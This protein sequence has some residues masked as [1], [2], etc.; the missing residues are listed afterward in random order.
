MFD[1]LTPKI[2][3]SC[4]GPDDVPQEVFNLCDIGLLVH[5]ATIK[6]E[7]GYEYTVVTNDLKKDVKQVICELNTILLDRVQ[8]ANE[9]RDPLMREYN[10]EDPVFAV[11]QGKLIPFSEVRR[12]T[13]KDVAFLEAYNNKKIF[14]KL[15]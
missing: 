6:T 3:S 8:K 2:D 12:F 13:M 15:N 14:F 11:L 4:F 5:G 10:D 7:I 1:F 9:E